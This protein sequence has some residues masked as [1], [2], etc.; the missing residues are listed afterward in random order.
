MGLKAVKRAAPHFHL[1]ARL[2]RDC[3][4]QHPL[5][6][7]SCLALGGAFRP[8]VLQL[9]DSWGPALFNNVHTR[10]DGNKTA[11]ELRNFARTLVPLSLYAAMAPDKASEGAVYRALPARRKVL[12]YVFKQACSLREKFPLLDPLAPPRH[13]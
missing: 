8:Y 5:D 3:H 1:A 6:L 10:L 12:G 7:T 4:K 2:C 9:A 11:R 13:W